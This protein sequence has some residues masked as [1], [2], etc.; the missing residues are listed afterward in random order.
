MERFCILA[1][2]EKDEN[3]LVTQKVQACLSGYGKQVSVLVD[4]FS[5][6]IGK[7]ISE[8]EA[9]CVLVLGGDGTLIRA[10]NRLLG[11]SI[12]IFGINLGTLGFLTETGIAGMEQALEQLVNGEYEIETRMMLQV[13]AGEDFEDTALN[14][15]V[16]TRS[17]FSRLIS[18]R[19]Y[20]NE[21]LVDTYRGDGV[22]IATP[23]GS[24][25]YNLSAGGPVVLP[26]ASLI[27]ITPICPHSLNARSII[28]SDK[29]SLRLVIEKE[30]KTQEE[31]AIVTVDGRNAKELR[32]ADWIT[33]EKSAGVTHLVKLKDRTFFEILREKFRNGGG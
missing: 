28:V 17:G 16:I 33:I 29:D 10:A 24:T 20:V 1:N 2:K 6:E 11:S 32:A 8:I 23:T 26:N 31:E 4:D 3:L 27:V 21:K 18:V 25:G 5:E 22:I 14:D 9:D 12:P 30:K 19:V 15:V 7:C 13:N